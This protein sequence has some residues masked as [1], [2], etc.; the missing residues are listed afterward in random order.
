MRSD[1]VYVKRLSDFPTG[2]ESGSQ[3]SHENLYVLMPRGLIKFAT[4][5]Y[6]S[7]GY[8]SLNERGYILT[9]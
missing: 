7:I 5:F 9:I 4:I 8:D 6:H 1:L 2:F 3:S